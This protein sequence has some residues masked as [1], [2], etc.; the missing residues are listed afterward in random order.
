M[1]AA[2]VR[3]GQLLLTITACVW[4]SAIIAV[5]FFAGQ[6]SNMAE[7]VVAGVRTIGGFVCHQRPDRSFRTG[8]V[9][10]P[11]CARCTGIYVGAA[12]GSVTA[13]LVARRHRWTT[14][15]RRARAFL[16]LAALPT[17]ATLALEVIAG[18]ASSNAVRGLAG[19]PL[20]TAIAWTL[21]TAAGADP[22]VEVH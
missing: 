6:G 9:V 20:G 11:V 8:G 17:V 1:S 3:S 7:F 12:L 10:W 22:S 4:A 2:A 13:I 15:V 18:F 16:T 21:V 19:I 5:V 14:F